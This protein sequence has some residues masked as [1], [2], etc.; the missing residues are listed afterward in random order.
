MLKRAW[1][2]LVVLFWVAMNV[3]L[4]RAEMMTP[5]PGGSPVSAELVWERVLTAP[6]ES[7][8]EIRRQDRKLGWIRW[9]PRVEEDPEAAPPAAGRSEDEL[10]EGRVRRVTGYTI[11][12]DGSLAPSEEPQRYRL[13]GQLEFDADRQ[14]RGLRLRV[15]QRPMLWE[16]QAEAKEQVLTLRLGDE[17]QP[18]EQRFRLDE[19]SR[20]EALLAGLGVPLPPGLLPLLLPP[21]LTA[22]PRRLALGLQWDARSDWFYLGSARVRVF[23]VSARLLDRYEVRL[24]LSRVGE[25]L[26]LELPRQITLVNDALAHFPAHD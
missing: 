12:L 9:T 4:W 14:W 3:L 22:G 18:W 7:S 24:V 16:V 13:N 17:N 10:P 21:E 6:D 15:T 8:L 11:L 1:F 5:P 20:P 19:L 23:R 2:C 26:R 25:I